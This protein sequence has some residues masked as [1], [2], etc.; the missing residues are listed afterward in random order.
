MATTR[1]VSIEARSLYD[2]VSEAF[3]LT[4][5]RD[6][7]QRIAPAGIKGDISRHLSRNVRSS[8][9]GSK[10][11]KEEPEPEPAATATK[12]RSTT[13][14]RPRTSPAQQ[15]DLRG[16]TT[17]YSARAPSAV[18]D[19]SVREL[20]RN[21]GCIQQGRGSSY[22]TDSDNIFLIHP[23]HAKLDYIFPSGCYS[24]GEGRWQNLLLQ[25]CEIV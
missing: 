18:V 13:S 5:K 22:T 9:E 23:S 1:P 8:S 4:H 7:A 24:S 6:Q 2:A 14:N 16:T 15:G 3:F 20:S 25:P 10:T 12:A 17:A 11:S 21:F 19:P